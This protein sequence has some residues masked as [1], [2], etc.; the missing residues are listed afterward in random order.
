[1]KVL[2]YN[3]NNKCNGLLDSP[4][5]LILA[6]SSLIAFK[7]VVLVAFVNQLA[8][9]DTIY[10]YRVRFAPDLTEILIVYM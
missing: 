3:A 1:M 9:A 10:I 7:L 6:F 2:L 4:V 5:P 8:L